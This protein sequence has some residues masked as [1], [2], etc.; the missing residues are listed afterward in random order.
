M[1][2]DIGIDL[3]TASTLVNIRGKGV[4]IKEPSMVAYDRDANKA[5]AFG[6]EARLI[7]G[8]MPGNIISITP[9]KYGVISDYSVAEQMI[10]YFMQKA[11]GRRTLQKPRVTISVPVGS[12]E[13]ERKAV[14]EAAYSAGAREVYIIEE[15]IAAAIGTG[16]DITKPF[17]NL[18]VNI[19]AGV[20][21]IA[22]ISLRGTI[23][24]KSLKVGG[25]DMDEVIRRYIMQTH[26]MIVG[27]KSAEDIKIQIGSA[28][29]LIEEEEMEV[30]GRDIVSG[31][32]KTVS[33]TSK[34]VE[35]LLAGICEQIVEGILTV[36][37]KAPPELSADILERGIVLTGGGA[38][39]RGMEEL[40]EERMGI[41][42]LTAEDPTLVVAK[43]TGGYISIL[44]ERKDG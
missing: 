25:N 35:R 12:T 37:E 9:L 10:Q 14:E 30:Y 26:D 39:L 41:H 2:I 32:P 5:K 43:G 11:L 7:L 3:G 31:L 23:A 15:P 21:D 16:I 27:E 18:I 29:P 8:R 20:T 13:V 17:G 28:F 24:S 33:I 36:I 1:A 22:I 44:N 40:I 38:L 19:G 34:E 6:E 42:T 4:V